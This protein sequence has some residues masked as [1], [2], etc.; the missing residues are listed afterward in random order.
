M[1]RN[2]KLLDVLLDP[3][4]QENVDGAVE[5]GSRHGP[6]GAAGVRSRYQLVVLDQRR[7]ERVLLKTEMLLAALAP[8]SNMPS[9][10]I[11]SPETAKNISSAAEH[12]SLPSDVRLC[13][14][15]LPA[16]SRLPDRP[17]GGTCYIAP[18]VNH[19]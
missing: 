16:R 5:G 4:T 6:G 9:S 18:S 8:A 11:P 14:A 1:C 19:V 17:V 10:F 15:L 7:E 2:R 12:R 13:C 3:C